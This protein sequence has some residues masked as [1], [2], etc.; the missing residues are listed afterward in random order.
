MLAWRR[1]AWSPQDPSDGTARPVV[2]SVTIPDA[3][4]GPKK[5]A[6]GERVMSEGL[7]PR[8]A[9]CKPP[10]QE[11]VGGGGDGRAFHADT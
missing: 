10:E 8:A 1:E 4:G 6:E 11:E 3:Q 5:K 7:S 9:V 2:R